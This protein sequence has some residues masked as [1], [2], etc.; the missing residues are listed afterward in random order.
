MKV[1][2]ISGTYYP[3]CGGMSS[4]IGTLSKE[5]RNNGDNVHILSLSSL[6]LPIRAI[7]LGVISFF[8]SFRK[9]L[10]LYIRNILLEQFLGFAAF[11]LCL[12]ENVSV[13][14]AHDCIALNSVWSSRVLLNTPSVLTV[15]GYLTNEP[16]A[17]GDLD[18]TANTLRKLFT[19]E[20]ERAYKK[21]N[22]IIAVDSRIKKHIL[23]FI[24]GSLKVSS[25]CNF[26]DP[27]EFL[28]DLKQ[29]DCRKLFNL[30]SDKIIVLI[31][32]R[33]VEKCGVFLP[34]QAL[35][36][37]PQIIRNQLL[38]VYCGSGPK[39]K[40][41]ENLIIK[42]KLTNVVLMGP[43]S[44]EKMKYLYRS[45]DIVLIPSIPVEGV[46]EATSISALEAMAMDIPVIASNIGGLTEIIV[47]GI[48][49]FLIE[50]QPEQIAEMLI[51]F[52]NNELVLRN[53]ESKHA[54]EQHLVDSVRKIKSIYHKAGK[55]S[56]I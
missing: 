30:P 50:P 14:H 19:K 9:G 34:I 35:E 26:V 6:P 52:Q 46:E 22:Q 23:G 31:P 32:R 16:L 15:H 11:F 18:K 40:D 10:G 28:V 45:S 55:F 17:H 33:L 1:L 2:I 56:N 4:H 38:L 44:H 25:M 49:G 20:E 54:A 39:K 43:L 27:S 42:N 21:S 36:K 48:N 29:D 3:H 53:C 13:I 24:P 8:D 41:I 5:L 47:N 37:M 12:K 7:L 51:K